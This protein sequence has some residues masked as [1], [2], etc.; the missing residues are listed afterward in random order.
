VS[1]YPLYAFEDWDGTTY[2]EHESE[3]LAKQY[4]CEKTLES[5]LPMFI[6]GGIG[7]ASC[8]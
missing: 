3:A 2:Y 5:N 8:H 4:N 1:D 7:N 6:L